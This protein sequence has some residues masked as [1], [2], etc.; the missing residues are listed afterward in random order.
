MRIRREVATYAML[1]STRNTN[2]NIVKEEKDAFRSML[3]NYS[4]DEGQPVPAEAL[5]EI[6]AGVKNV[7]HATA[8]YYISRKDEVSADA[9]R[10]FDPTNAL[11][12]AAEELYM[13]VNAT[14][15]CPDM[16]YMFGE[17]IHEEIKKSAKVIQHEYMRNDELGDGAL[18]DNIATGST[19]NAQRRKNADVLRRD[20][21]NT[22]ISD[23]K[24]NDPH[25][26]KVGKL[27]AEYQALQRR[28]AG[29]GR[30][31]RFFH[32][33]ENSARNELLK[34]MRE[35]LEV[36]FQSSE[37]FNIETDTPNSARV[38][39]L[40]S[41]VDGHFNKIVNDH[42]ENI[43]TY[44][45]SKS[46]HFDGHLLVDPNEANLNRVPLKEMEQLKNDTDLHKVTETK[47]KEKAIEKEAPAT[48]LTK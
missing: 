45:N 31:W 8:S 1:N 30:I 41:Y 14:T 26:D 7:L 33:S 17:D 40:E 15:G 32:A 20:Y 43:D 23:V 44:F 42:L 13:L 6:K 3:Y 16:P 39:T 48:N 36:H 24:S 27:V 25:P 11:I 12:Q 10:N 38:S 9:K 18:R 28:Q 2:S 46:Y 35:A 19:Y 34:D 22:L 5:E 29:H 37:I 47:P 21:M 4:F